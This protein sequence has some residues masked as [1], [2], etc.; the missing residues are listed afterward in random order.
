MA[1]FRSQ[2]RKRSHSRPKPSSTI[3]RIP[4]NGEL[5]LPPER[6]NDNVEYKSKLI[7]PNAKRL[8]H[9]CTQMKWRLQQGDGEA[10]Y[11][12]G[13]E[14]DGRM[15]GL[16]NDEMS[17][18]MQTLCTMAQSVGAVLII[19]K[20]QCVYGK[21]GEAGSRRV[22]EALIRKLPDDQQFSDL[23]VAILG[24]ASA[25]KSTLC[26]VLTQ[27]VLDNG[28]GKCRLNLL[29][30]M[31]E[32]R[33]GKTSSVNLDAFGFDKAG[34][35]LNYSENSLEEIVKHSTK[36][37]TLIDLA[38]DR[39]Y[40]KTTIYGVSGYTPHYCALLV[41]AR[42][43]WTQ[44]SQEHFE[45]AKAFNVPVFIIVTK[46]DLVTEQR[47]QRIFQQIQAVV[48]R[49]HPNL[50]V[51]KVDDEEMAEKAAQDLMNN[52]TVPLIQIS[53]VNGTGLQ[54]LLTFFRRLPARISRRRAASEAEPPST[55]FH[56]D[57]IFRVC[58]VGW[59]VY[60]LMAEGSVKENDWVQ[61]GP[62]SQDQFHFGQVK[63]LRRNKQPV[64]TVNAGE[65]ASLAVSFEKTGAENWL[66]KGMVLM[67]H[68]ATPRCCRRFVARFCLL[69]HPVDELCIGFQG[70]V[71]IRSLRRTVTIV[72][73]SS[74]SLKCGEPTDVTFEFYG[75]PS[76]VREGEHVFFRERTTKGV[77]QVLSIM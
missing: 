12:I 36:L 69:S 62:D 59:V 39:K 55:L 4:S 9:L 14:D 44:M 20:D 71:Y 40:M 34:N 27:G 70:T 11:E 19:L 3:S 54:T 15:T 25:G 22:I 18:S 41:N 65:T 28:N 53:S 32:V 74:E 76:Y 10:I 16:E 43:G 50:L 49:S 77:G 26:G 38:G 72:D 35:V 60:G 51:Q 8:Q 17:I 13:V 29:R 57:E 68:D 31:H 23:R 73:F 46:V 56:V 58:E 75:G 1:V 64:W 7:N 30:Y 66:R 45:L 2:S 6:E 42:I 61:I 63:S 47:L 67:N 5:K 24:N 21:P 33:T 52:K 48:K 37:I